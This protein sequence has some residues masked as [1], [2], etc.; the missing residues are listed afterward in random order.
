MVKLFGK[1]EYELESAVPPDLPPE[2]AKLPDLIIASWGAGIFS[3][4]F[5]AMMRTYIPNYCT[6]VLKWDSL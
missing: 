4:F 6:N 2:Q 3:G 1:Q 5:V